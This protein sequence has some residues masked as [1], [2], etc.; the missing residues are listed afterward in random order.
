MMLTWGSKFSFG[1]GFGALFGAVVMGLVTGGDFVGVIS[2]GY[3]GGV[4]DHIAYGI[5]IFIG[6][7]MIVVGVVTTIARDGDPEELTQR[8]GISS[9]SAVTPPAFP[10]YWAPLSAFGVVALIVGVALSPAFI[11]LGVIA[12]AVVAL[13]WCIQAWADHASG[14]A[15][16]N[17]VMRQRLIGPV[18]LPLLSTLA[19]A[20]VVIG[21]SRVLLAVSKTGSVVVACVAAALIFGTIILLSRVEVSRRIM[22]GIVAIFAVAVL[23]GGIVGAAAGERDF[24]HVDEAGEH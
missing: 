1:I 6:L 10:S 3:K 12:L 13:E 8:T 23:A 17:E 11:I 21:S 4:G 16:V 24:H 18:E 7:A 2:S 14:D 9:V 15:E 22:T 20:A 5:L 19:I